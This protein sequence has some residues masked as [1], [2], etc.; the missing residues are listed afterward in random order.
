MFLYKTNLKMHNKKRRT[1]PSLAC[2]FNKAYVNMLVLFSSEHNVCVCVCVYSL[3]AYSYYVH[4][5]ISSFVFFSIFY[6]FYNK[7][8]PIAILSTICNINVI[9]HKIYI[10]STLLLN[11]NSLH[12]LLLPLPMCFLN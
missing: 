11:H 7:K 10:I 4:S 9:F 12:L 2:M 8:L 5:F 1:Y 3:K 6:L